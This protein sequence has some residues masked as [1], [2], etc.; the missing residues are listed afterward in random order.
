MPGSPA[1]SAG[2][3]PLDIVLVVNE[4]PA[5][6]KGDLFQAVGPVYKPDTKVKVEVFRA[7]EEN[8]KGKTITISMKPEEQKA[9]TEQK[10]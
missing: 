4:K 2:I 10:E 3:R 5:I 9:S 6:F 7:S 8:G 1:H